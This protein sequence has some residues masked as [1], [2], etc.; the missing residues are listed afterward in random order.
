MNPAT[1]RSVSAILRYAGFKSCK[2]LNR[3]QRGMRDVRDFTE[4]Y[5][6]VSYTSGVIRV[7]YRAHR[8]ATQADR[9]AMLARYAGAILLAEA[10][11]GEDITE[12]MVDAVIALADEQAEREWLEAHPGWE[13]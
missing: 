1:A 4:G 13:D 3:R 7:R 12:E 9:D 2:P 10:H 6:V 11:P 8:S 5:Q